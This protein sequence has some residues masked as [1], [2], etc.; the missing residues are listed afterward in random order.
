MP[1]HVTRMRRA[2]ALV[3]IAA[4][5]V[6]LA[7]CGERAQELQAKAPDAAP[8]SGKPTAF[9]GTSGWTGGDQAAW[10]QQIRTRNQNQ[11]EYGR[12]P[13]TRP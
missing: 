6:L 3:L 7:G 1:Q 2:A 11:N 8:W 13:A 5:G 9:A 4:G 12:A 10:E